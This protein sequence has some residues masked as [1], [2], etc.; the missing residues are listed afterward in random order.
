[1]FHFAKLS[2]DR[3]EWVEFGSP[4]IAPL[5]SKVQKKRDKEHGKAGVKKLGNKPS[6]I[7]LHPKSR[8]VKKLVINSSNADVA[9]EV[10]KAPRKLKPK[11]KPVPTDP[12][13]ENAFVVGGKAY[14]E[15]YVCLP[16]N[17]F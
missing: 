5:Y 7:P 4:R 16:I 9:A 12:T 8:P 13:D 11:K 1:M 3:D 2:S 6:S 17:C 10:E 15:M 14:H